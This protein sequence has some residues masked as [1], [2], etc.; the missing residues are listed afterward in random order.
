MNAPRYKHDCEIWNPEN[1]LDACR[2]VGCLR[3][4]DLYVHERDYDGHHHVECVARFSDDGP[5]YLSGPHARML[6]EEF[7]RA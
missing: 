3:E 6:I 7:L 4:F 5:D 1:P 2:F